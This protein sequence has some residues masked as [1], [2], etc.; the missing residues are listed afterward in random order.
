MLEVRNKKW[1]TGLS[2]D[3]VFIYFHILVLQKYWALTESIISLKTE[4]AVFLYCRF[5]ISEGSGVF[6]SDYLEVVTF[7][8]FLCGV[9]LQY[10]RP[11]SV[12]TFFIFWS[13]RF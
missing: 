12:D 11:H 1:H 6:F 13:F 3:I 8:L 2:Y 9:G 4:S 7:A 5:S 10:S